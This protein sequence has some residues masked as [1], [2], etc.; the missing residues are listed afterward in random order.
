VSEKPAGIPE[1]QLAEPELQDEQ[2]DQPGLTELRGA[3]ATR[4]R[5][6]LPSRA[7]LSRDGIA[8]LNLAVANVPDGLANG[9]LVGVN[10]IFG[11][12]ATMMG[13][14]VGGLFSSS[15]L[16]VIT[17]TAAASLTASQAL[18]G[19]PE[20]SRA[21]A[22]VV[23]V[24]LVGVFQLLLGLLRLGR[25]ARFVSYSVTTGLLT[26]ISVLLILSQLPAMTGRTAAGPNKVAQTLDLLSH[27]GQL[28]PYALATGSIALLLAILLP[29]TGLR[30]AGR[31]AAVVAASGLAALL[32]LD[33]VR[34]V[35]DIGTIT[36]GF[37]TPAVPS[38]ASMLGVVTG[39]LSV[40]VVTLV[41]GVGV[42]QTVPNLDGTRTSISRDFV[43]QGLAN[44][45]S[46][47]FR[48]LP[49]GGSL[50]STALTVLSGAVSRWAAI[51]G[52]LFMAVLLL[53]APGLVAHVAMPALA[54]LLILAGASSLKYREFLVVWRTGWPSRLAGVTTFFCTL[55]LPIQAAVGIGMVLAALL[56]MNESASDISVVELVPRPDGRVEERAAPA[57]LAPGQVTVLDIYG[58]LFYA[59]A[60][61]LE[62]FLPEPRGAAGP[63]VVLR[64]RGRSSLG[65]TL[66]DVL[67]RYAGTLDRVRGRLYLAGLGPTAL[68]QLAR[69]G[70]LAPAGK[71][72]AFPATAARGESTDQARADA[73]RW[74]EG[75]G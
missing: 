8:G 27:P 43:A 64:L 22:M 28:D 38:F 40:A 63:A 59:G 60:R 16:M 25:L 52:G 9:A 48:G 26:G 36:A 73:E 55:L 31:M 39:A 10:P 68:Q 67:V 1:P 2:L 34:T 51:L 57:A 50:S 20:A 72:H 74:L 65:A 75:R 21:E 69:A 6:H 12:Y 54:A 18:T 14:I 5:R 56:H 62:Q 19:I 17:T 30:Y 37:P 42:S 49:V 46:G 3:V 71:I 33:S 13:P 11:L 45:A 70:A 53:L 4:F 41:Q 58:H 47:L 24:I 32:S 66:I 29:R 44:V 35:G 23:M 7:A 15:Q 61:T